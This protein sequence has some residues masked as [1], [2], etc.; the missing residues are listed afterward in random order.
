M[1][2]TNSVP[3]PRPPVPS[4][5]LSFAC[6]TR[7]CRQQR[8]L[9]K[10]KLHP[11]LWQ[12]AGSLCGHAILLPLQQMSALLPLPSSSR[13]CVFF[14]FSLEIPPVQDV[15]YFTFEKAESLH[16]AEFPALGPALPEQPQM[17]ASG[18][19]HPCRGRGNLPLC[20]Y[21]SCWSCCEV[22]RTHFLAEEKQVVT[23][24]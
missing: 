17:F 2:R 5:P 12:A 9:H 1:Q 21:S 19:L 14:H 8:G 13:L 15:F 3:P 10:D 16:R 24:L 7:D 18:S 4:D 20:H 22:G 6:S 23:S 11:A